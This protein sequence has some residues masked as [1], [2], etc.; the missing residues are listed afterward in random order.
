MNLWTV[1]RTATTTDS[2]IMHVFQRFIF[3]SLARYKYLFIFSPFI[4]LL[5][6]G[7]IARS[8]F[9]R[10]PFRSHVRVLPCANLT[11]AFGLIYLLYCCFFFIHFCFTDFFVMLYVLML[12]LPLMAAA[13]NLLGLFS[14]SFECFY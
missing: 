13:I 2:T 9:L 14:A 10:L 7:G 8:S 4:F 6:S 1:P 12:P 11:H 5:W 3:C